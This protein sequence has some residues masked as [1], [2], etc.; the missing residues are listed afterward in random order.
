MSLGDGL[1]CTD[2]DHRITVWNPGAAAIFGYKPAEMIGRR[3]TRSARAPT[4]RRARVLDP[5]RC[6]PALLVPGGAVDRVRGAAQERRDVSG[7]GE[8]LGLAGHGRLPVRRDPARHLGAQARS[9]THPLSGRTRFADR[10]CQP[11]H[12]ACAT[13]RDDRR[14]ETGGR[15]VALLVL[16]LD[17]FQQINDMLG[18]ASGDLVLRAVAE[19]LSQRSATA[20]GRAAERR[21]IRDR[22]SLRRLTKPSHSSPSGSRAHSTAAAG[23]QRASIASRSASASPSIRTAAHRRRTARATAIWRCAAPRRPGA[24]AM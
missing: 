7:R 10:P 12:A 4:A 14:G 20:V 6:A 18:H 11:Q 9:R 24:A 23:G 21:R 22:A 13:G 17:G 8:L 15:E 3:S 2:E 5:R 19:R 1:V 16:G